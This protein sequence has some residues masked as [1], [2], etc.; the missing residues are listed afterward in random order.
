MVIIENRGLKRSLLLILFGVFLLPGLVISQEGSD[1]KE[2]AT[3]KAQVNGNTAQVDT[4][5]KEATNLR[6][7]NPDSAI[8][9]AQKA[10]ELSGDIDYEVGKAE[11]FKL[12]GL[13]Y[14]DKT[15]FSEALDYFN[16]ALIVYQNEMDTVGISSIQNNLGSVYQTSGNDPKALELFFASLRNGELVKDP[17]RIGTAYVN[18]GTVYSNDELTYDQAIENYQKCIPYFEEIDYTL[19][20]AVA[21]V[22]IGELYLNQDEP[23]LSLPF[24]NDALDGFREIGIDPATP[25]NLLARAYLKLKDF[26]RAQ[27]FFQQALASATEKETRSEEA[28]AYLGLGEMSLQLENPAAAIDYFNN[29]LR[30]ARETQLLRETSEAFKGL[31]RAYSSQGDFKSAYQ[32]QQSYTEVSDSLRTSDYA[33][34]MSQ[35]RTVFDLER[36][37]QEIELLNAENEV[38]QLQIQEDARAKRSLTIILFL[39]LAIIAGFIFQYFYIKRTNK[40]LAFERNRSD[41]ILLNILPEEVAEELKQK[42]FTEAKEFDNITVMFTDFKGFS[43]VAERI[44]AEKLVKSVDYYFK[45]FDEIIERHNLEKIKTIG[46]AYMCAGGLPTPNQTH[47]R[48]AFEAAL[49]ILKFVKETELNPPK[50]IYPFQIRI[51]LSSGPVVAGVVGTKK[52]AYDIW[53]NTVNIASRMESGS[54]EGRINVSEYIY[55]ELKD[56]FEFTYRGE[57]QVKSQTFKMY[58]AEIPEEVP[59]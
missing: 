34:E 12:I 36:K 3:S 10:I 20:L 4:L 54:V 11:G 15:N 6:F 53:G 31:S 8:V 29:A 9:I 28:N 14:S 23:A 37:E 52:F 41:Q 59:A 27:D 35:L 51:G 21:N 50:G 7:N 58:F 26:N 22:N 30:V 16:R 49:E 48:D 1:K 19:G 13:V 32:A 5:L 47:A 56:D 44:S 38:N 39:F 57:L 46:D 55:K 24:L 25:L 45:N 18:I 33:N 43:Q 42:G 40:R 17:L 2:A